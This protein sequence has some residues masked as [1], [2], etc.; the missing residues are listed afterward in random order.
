MVFVV[1]DDSGVRLVGKSHHGVE[2]CGGM[3]RARCAASVE[4]RAA[5]VQ[6]HRKKRLLQ[7]QQ[8]VLCASETCLESSEYEVGA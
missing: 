3:P 2:G 8:M 1:D 4:K 7:S 6:E 5:H